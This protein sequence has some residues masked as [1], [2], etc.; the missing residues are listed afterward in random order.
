LTIEHIETAD[1][2]PY[3]F[4]KKGLKGIIE[5]KLPLIS[6]SG[7]ANLSKEKTSSALSQCKL[8]IT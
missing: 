2:V 3:P 8:Q 6:L 7:R 1:K 5:L 4:E